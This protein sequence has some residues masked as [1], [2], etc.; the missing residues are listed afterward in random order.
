MFVG[1]ESRYLVTDQLETLD[2]V[3]IEASNVG[4]DPY[5]C[6]SLKLEV[7]STDRRGTIV[8]WGTSPK[9]PH[10]RL[11]VGC[12]IAFNFGPLMTTFANSIRSGVQSA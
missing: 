5:L 9:S 3:G 10:L 6:E 11:Y 4:R 1:F 2:R 12:E 7:L 8:R